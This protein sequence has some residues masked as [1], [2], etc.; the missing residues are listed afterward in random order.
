MVRDYVGPIDSL[1]DAFKARRHL[2]ALCLGCGHVALFDPRSLIGKLGY[3]SLDE[4]RG[5]LRCARCGKRCPVLAPQDKP[6]S[7]MR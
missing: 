1:G 3:R 2:W 5:R 7:S 4:A 6:W